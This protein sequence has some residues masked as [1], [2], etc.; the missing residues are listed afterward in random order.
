MI[1][2]QNIGEHNQKFTNSLSNSAVS[3][4]I[5]FSDLPPWPQL[6]QQIDFRGVPG[7]ATGNREL[8]PL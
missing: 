1:V 3:K 4:A 5:A 6:L 8:E 7:H 2:Q